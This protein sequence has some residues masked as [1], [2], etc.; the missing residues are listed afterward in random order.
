MDKKKLIGTIIGVAMFAALIAGA[1]FAWLTITATGT[2]NVYSGST[3]NFIVDYKGGT[4]VTSLNI[5]SSPDASTI[6]AGKGLVEVKANRVTGSADGTLNIKFHLDSATTSSSLL[7]ASAIKYKVCAASACTGALTADGSIGAG[8]ANGDTIL[9]TVNTIPTSQTS[10]YIYM[11][12]DAN[13]ITEAHMNATFSGYV[14]A[15]AKQTD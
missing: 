6:T 13:V 3:M 2:N 4:N 1:T 10:Y 15:D 11:W 14:Y 9:Y 5:A 8:D 7:T 12:L